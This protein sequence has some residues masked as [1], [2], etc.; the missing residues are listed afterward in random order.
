M[1]Y[2]GK[3]DAIHFRIKIIKVKRWE[4]KKKKKDEKKKRKKK[5]KKKK[6]KKLNKIKSVWGIK[7]E[8]SKN[9]S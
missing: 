5:I 8:I 7:K 4:L 1:G 6:L 2:I 9:I 3:A